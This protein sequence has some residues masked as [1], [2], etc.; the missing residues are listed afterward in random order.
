MGSL[1]KLMDNTIVDILFQKSDN[2]TECTIRYNQLYKKLNERY[3]EIKGDQYKEIRRDKYNFHVKRLVEEEILERKETGKKDRSV[4]YCLTTKARNEKLLQLLE[5]KSKK[6]QKQYRIDSNEIKR[7]RLFLLLFFSLLHKKGKDIYSDE[8]LRLFLSDNNLTM[9]DLK[10]KNIAKS[11]TPDERIIRY[12]NI[13]ELRIYK[14]EN[15]IKYG[16]KLSFKLNYYSTLLPGFTLIELLNSE[17]LRNFGY[18]SDEIK[19][20]FYTLKQSKYVEEV[21]E[22]KNE[23]RY[24]TN[25]DYFH[26]LIINLSLMQNL[27]T[28]KMMRIWIYKRRITNEEKKWMTF[29]KGIKEFE[30]VM[31]EIREYKFAYRKMKN[32]K[33]AQKEVAKEIIYWDKRITK[34]FRGIKK[35]FIPE[36]EKYNFPYEKI[37]DILYPKLFHGY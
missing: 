9:E 21:W 16:K 3:K 15:I 24:G 32:K 28:D 17:E 11:V 13:G 35:S 34:E 20:A 37:M 1:D 14:Y 30:R 8:E 12:K 31:K 10:V 4:N 33:E 6:E 29:F 36:I 2:I 27:I 19:E 26:Q 25:N 7:T 22:Y 5:F 18:T 23:P